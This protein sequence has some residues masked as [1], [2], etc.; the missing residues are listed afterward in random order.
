M[1]S[2]DCTIRYRTSTSNFYRNNS[3]ITWITYNPSSPPTITDQFIQWE[4]VYLSSASITKWVGLTWSGSA[5]GVEADSDP[6]TPVHLTNGK[7]NMR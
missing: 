4:I 1:Y 6:V 2:G 3:S 7:Y 5:P